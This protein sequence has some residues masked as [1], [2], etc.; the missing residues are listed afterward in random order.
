MGLLIAGP[1]ANFRVQRLAT[2]SHHFFLDAYIRIALT[3]E[4]LKKVI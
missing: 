1:E 2:S 3:Y 4:L